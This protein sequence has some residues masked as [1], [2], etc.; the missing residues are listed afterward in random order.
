MKKANAFGDTIENRDNNTTQES[1]GD[2]D[3]SIR[4]A[5]SS[6]RL[7]Y[8]TA[9]KDGFVTP[10]KC[11]NLFGSSDDSI[12]NHALERIKRRFDFIPINSSRRL[13]FSNELQI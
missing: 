11:I 7:P 8:R 9:V 13:D 3:G 6:T 5:E 12:K 10:T 1:N 4:T 2:K